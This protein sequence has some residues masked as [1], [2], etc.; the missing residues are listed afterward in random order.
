MGRERKGA[1]ISKGH[2]LVLAADFSSTQQTDETLRVWHKKE[3]D[4]NQ[5]TIFTLHSFFFTVSPL[6]LWH[7][8]S[9]SS[10]CKPTAPL[11]PR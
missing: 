10:Q 5:G 4:V 7:R 3:K 11:L 8:P 9:T 1:H 6:F 2:F